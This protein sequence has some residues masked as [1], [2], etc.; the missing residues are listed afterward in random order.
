MP[1]NFDYITQC[2]KQEQIYSMQDQMKAE[3]QEFNT[4]GNSVLQEVKRGDYKIKMP[5]EL[6]SKQDKVVL[7]SEYE[8]PKSKFK[9]LLSRI[10]NSFKNFFRLK[11]KN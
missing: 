5:K 7:S 1:M 3:F 2:C 8:K 10:G 4:F 6:L 11:E 9:Q